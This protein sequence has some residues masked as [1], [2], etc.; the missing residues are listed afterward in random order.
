MVDAEEVLA[1]HPARSL[2]LWLLVWREQFGCGAYRDQQRGKCALD[3]FGGR[4]CAE[5][6]SSRKCLVNDVFE[7]SLY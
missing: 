2:R 3:R 5:L 4:W 7:T 6:P 1:A